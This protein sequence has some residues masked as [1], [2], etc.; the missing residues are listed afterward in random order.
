L[1]RSMTTR[2]SGSVTGRSALITIC[3][4]EEA[5]P[6]KCSSA[7]V[8]RAEGVPA[9]AAGRPLLGGQSRGRRLRVV[10]VHAL[11]QQGASDVAGEAG[12]RGD[13]GRVLPDG[14]LRCPQVSDVQRVPFGDRA[15]P[16]GALRQARIRV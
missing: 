12:A 14:P 5:L 2:T 1:A 3:S 10:P 6:P 16:E 9:V 13:D 7:N 4:A 11:L 15:A 8:P